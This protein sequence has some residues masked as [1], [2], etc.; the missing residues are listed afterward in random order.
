[1]RKVASACILQDYTV[2]TMA[3]DLPYEGA[4]SRPSTQKSLWIA[5]VA[6]DF[7]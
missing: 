4:P 2:L 5:V 7:E 3:E 1:M 6:Y